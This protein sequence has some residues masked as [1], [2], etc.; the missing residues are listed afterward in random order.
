[1]A[2]ILEKTAEFRDHS[3]PGRHLERAA[4][5]TPCW[6]KCQR[7]IRLIEALIDLANRS[8]LERILVLR[9]I[10]RPEQ[11]AKID[12]DPSLCRFKAENGRLSLLKL[13]FTVECVETSP[14]FADIAH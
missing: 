5:E 2:A 13:K 14:R 9:G 6:E 1:M 8:P 12:R 3:G 7:I 10:V 11:Q 4:T